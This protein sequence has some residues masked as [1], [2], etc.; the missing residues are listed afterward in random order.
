MSGVYAIIPARGGSKGIPRKNLIDFCG[1]PLLAWSIIQAKTWS[2]RVF[3]TSDD[4]EILEVSGQFDAESIKRPDELSTDTASSEDALLHAQDTWKQEGGLPE[5]VV[6]LQATSPLRTPDDIGN[7]VRSLKDQK[8]D[9]LFAMAVLDDFCVWEKC[10]GKL[11]GLTYDP[12]N[13][14]CRQNRPPL[15]L[16]NGSIYVYKPEVLETHR[17]RLGGRIGMYEMPYWQSYEIDSMEQI[18]VCEYYFNKN[19]KNLYN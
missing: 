16:E 6:F 4:Q 19:L 1:K 5:L 15:F 9:S 18:E 3:V 10:N 14:G 17:N 2:D 13:R 7:A 11:Q 12:L 8:A